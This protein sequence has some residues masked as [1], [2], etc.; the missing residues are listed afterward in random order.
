MGRRFPPQLAT[1]VAELAKSIGRR[2]AP[3]AESLGGFRYGA[4]ARRRR[5]VSMLELVIA[6]SMLAGVMTGLSLV[7]RT[8]RQSWDTIDSE[9]AVLQQM[10]ATSRHFV[11]TARE[12]KGVV[13]IVPDGNAIT[14]AMP[15]D[16]SATW[17]WYPSRSGQRG[18]VTFQDSSLPSQSQLAH[19]IDALQFSSFAADGVTPTNDPD[20]IHVIEVKATVTLPRSAVPQR[21]TQSK[22]WIRSW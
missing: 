18:V 15:N 17:Q 4:I 2:A 19:D 9:Y 6:G 8:A 20:Q 3:R 5:G 13:T 7:L 22:V 1:P 10:H 21:T 16:Q 12:A 14:L 11:R